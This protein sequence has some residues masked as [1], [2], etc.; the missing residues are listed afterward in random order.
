[1][2]AIG[3]T[4][5]ILSAPLST[6]ETYTGGDHGHRTSVRLTRVEKAVSS[7]PHHPRHGG[8]SS[9]GPHGSTWGT[10]AMSDNRDHSTRG[11]DIEAFSATFLYFV[12]LIS[13]LY[14][15][16]TNVIHIQPLSKRK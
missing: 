5:E 1:M 15:N 6:L 2:W 7:G 8:S 4:M 3:N 10:A 9:D 12:K 16:K 11:K 14:V 13:H